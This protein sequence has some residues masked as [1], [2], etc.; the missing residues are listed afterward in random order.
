MPAD[1]DNLTS[2]AVRAADDA[3]ELLHPLIYTRMDAPRHDA[4][5]DEFEGAF[6]GVVDSLQKWLLAYDRWGG[7]H[8][9]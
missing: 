9:N 8:A 6:R 4:T 1:H 2:S 3:I 5:L 7:E